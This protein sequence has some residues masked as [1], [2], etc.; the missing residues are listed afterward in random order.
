MLRKDTKRTMVAPFAAALALA[1]GVPTALSAPVGYGLLEG[2]GSVVGEVG[3]DTI[4]TPE[5]WD[6]YCFWVSAG[7]A[8]TLTGNRLDTEHD[9]AMV[10][11][12]GQT[13]ESEGLDFLGSV[14]PGME[15]LTLADDE[16]EVPGPFADPQIDVALPVGGRYTLG[17]FDHEFDTPGPGPWAY[18]LDFAGLGQSTQADLSDARDAVGALVL[19]EGSQADQRRDTVYGNFLANATADSNTDACGLGDVAAARQARSAFNYLR[20]PNAQLAAASAS[21]RGEIYSAVERMADT[22]F[23]EVSAAGT[24]P[25]KRLNQA[26]THIANAADAA[27]TDEGLVQLSKA[28]DILKG[29]APQL[30]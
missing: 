15:W 19:T 20:T 16:L 5:A 28:I 12:R 23:G 3:G 8:I 27:G 2:T 25:A 18:A 26:A 21:I 29:E 1:V 13:N 24:A 4:L 9:P 10:L 11:L 30:S 14:Q 6:Y 22:R 17:F 7:D